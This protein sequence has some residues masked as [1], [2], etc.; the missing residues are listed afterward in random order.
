MS[1]PPAH[2]IRRRP[3][4]FR[5]VPLRARRDGWSEGRQCG[6]LALLYCTGSVG[7]AA[8]GVGMSRTSAYRLRARAGAESFAQAWDRVL[9]PPGSG[10]CAAAREDFRKVTDAVLLARVEAGFIKPVIYRGRMSAIRR[11]PDNSS[12]LRLLRRHPPAAAPR[13]GRGGGP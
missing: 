13:P 11:K 4:F 1:K 5:P 7:A 2:R 9:A 12:L 6:F 3:G 8:R 10:A